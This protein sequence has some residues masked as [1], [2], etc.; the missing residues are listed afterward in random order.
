MGQRW[1]KI[2]RH[3]LFVK[4]YLTLMFLNTEITPNYVNNNITF[5]LDFGIICSSFLH[6]FVE[7]PYNSNTNITCTLAE[8]ILITILHF[9]FIYFLRHSFLLLLLLPTVYRLIACFS[10][11]P[12][13]CLVLW[14]I[15]SPSFSRPSNAPMSCR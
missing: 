11:H 5:V 6:L 10:S 14:K 15:V 1:I 4:L 12:C 9:I 2:Y 8:C 7:S 13:P 3:V